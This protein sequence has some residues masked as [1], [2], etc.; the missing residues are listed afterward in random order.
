MRPDRRARRILLWARR[1][2][3]ALSLGLMLLVVGIAAV[4]LTTL[5]REL[6]WT[7]VRSALSSITSRQV[8][9]SLL[10]TAASY[11]TLTFYDVLALKAIGQRL[12]WWRAAL[13]SFTAYCFSHNFGFAPVTG[14]AARWR[15]YAGTGLSAADIARIVVI[16]GATFWLGVLLMFGLFM[17]AVPG[18]AR[19]HD[20]ALPYPLQA[21]LGAAILL[22]MLAYLVACARGRGPIRIFGW[23]LPV[24]TL[25]QALAQ[26]A[27][28][29]TDISIASAALLVLLPGDPW[30]LFG[31]F[32]VAYVIAM[33]LALVT[34]APGGLGVFEAVIL[35]TLPQ[36]DRAGLVSALI[37]YRIIY[38]WLPLIVSILL[39]GG[40]EALRFRDTPFTLDKGAQ[41]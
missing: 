31:S 11:F 38:Y 35:V 9:L 24:P 36:V 28:A 40:R 16:A 7:E 17:L 23:H 21:G 5:L 18:A 34:H 20:A 26:F 27:L 3:T 12:P 19:F 10:L 30:A 6:S 2:Q 37:V 32:L 41:S 15:A 13:G 25:G 14:G 8:A 39:L 1:R 4:A 33:V 29:A 22:A